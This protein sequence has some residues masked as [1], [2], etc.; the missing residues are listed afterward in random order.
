MA[1]T[2][3]MQTVVVVAGFCSVGFFVVVV[4]LAFFFFILLD[5]CLPLFSFFNFVF[6]FGRKQENEVGW[7]GRSGKSGGV[8][9]VE[10]H[11]QKCSV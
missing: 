9:V 11:A 5:F 1:S 3:R 10:K 8:R 2:N 7:V 4:V 6:V